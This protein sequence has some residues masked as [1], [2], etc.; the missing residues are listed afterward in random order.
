M[1]FD[2]E[3]LTSSPVVRVI[4][5]YFGAALPR[6]LQT[7]LLQPSSSCESGCETLGVLL[8]I[9]GASDAHGACVR[10]RSLVLATGAL[11]LAQGAVV[12]GIIDLAHGAAVAGM[13][14][15]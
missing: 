8:P 13:L 12:G 11:F 5:S 7:H 6:L 10:G 3:F 2:F 9:C 4:K 1:L 15:L 14:M